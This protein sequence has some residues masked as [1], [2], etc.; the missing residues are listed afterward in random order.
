MKFWLAFT[1]CVAAVLVTLIVSLTYYNVRTT[2]YYTEHGY[3]QVALPG[4]HDPVWTKPAAV[5]VK[6]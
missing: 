1:G 4:Q 3:V 5:E 2:A 6:P